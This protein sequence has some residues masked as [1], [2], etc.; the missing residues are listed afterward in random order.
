MTCATL[1]LMDEPLPPAPP[2]EAA[3]F[4]APEDARIATV[5]K[6]STRPSLVA[7]LL[8]G[9]LGL[10]LSQMLAA[11]PLGIQALGIPDDLDAA[12]R[13][14]AVQAISVRLA[15]YMACGCLSTVAVVAIALRLGAVPTRERLGLAW[16][17]I[18][19]SS[20]ALALLGTLAFGTTEVF[21]IDALMTLDWVPR[22]PET[23]PIVQLARL[24]NDSSLPLGLLLAVL[25][26]LCPGLAEE[27]VFRGYVQRGLLAR[28]RPSVAIG[29]TSVLFAI[30]HAPVQITG[31]MAFG[32]WIGWIAWRCD[33][34]LPGMALHAF[35]NI[36]AS[37]VGRFGPCDGTNLSG[38]S[39]GASFAIS[40]AT[41]AVFLL[42]CRALA[43]RLPE[44]P[45][46]FQ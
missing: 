34:I 40:T 4:D 44:A 3:D 39:A 26:G 17:R 20:F 36:V 21:L 27:M 35:N 22:L 7:V 6:A 2:K 11:I 43:R 41:V 33:S 18:G 23:S 30:L 14:V 46:R 25:S 1:P 45:P 24:M 12:A 8:M 16:R 28:W 38:L 32:A 42:C 10:P 37:I 15:M 29:V 9:T 31:A 19:G 13:K 5:P